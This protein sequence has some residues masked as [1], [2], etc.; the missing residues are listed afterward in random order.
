VTAPTDNGKKYHA[1]FTNASGSATTT[2]ATLT[3]TVNKITPMI[4]WANPADI[5]FGGALGSG[6]LNATANVAGTFAYTPPAGTVLPVGNGQT[7]SVLFTPADAV[8]YTTASASVLINVVSGGG[9]P[10]NLIV[11][12]QLSRDTNTD[13]VVV[14]LTVSNTGGSTASGAQLTAVQI[15]GTST[16][17][18]L[19]ISLGEIPA[20]GGAVTTV[21][22]PGSVGSSGTRAVL[23]VTGAFTG[24]AFGGNMRVSLP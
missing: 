10:A 3:V 21:R 17:T 1:V 20:G 9:T 23:G 11:A 7:L 24:G 5:V 4:T 12:T 16:T 8:N 22:L 19:P 13:E 18:P 14:T 6:Q 2:A 15:G